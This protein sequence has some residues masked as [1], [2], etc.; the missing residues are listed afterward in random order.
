MGSRAVSPGNGTQR[1]VTLHG[2]PI[3]VP[4]PSAVAALRDGRWMSENRET[5]TLSA[6]APSGRARPAGLGRERRFE[7]CPLLGCQCY[8]RMWR[9]LALGCGE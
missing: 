7:R 5:N 8:V 9:D 4:P 6:V 2:R 1:R 3:D